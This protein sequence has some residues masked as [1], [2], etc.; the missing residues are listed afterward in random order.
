MTWYK[1]FI[2]LRLVDVAD[3][4]K[5]SVLIFEKECGELVGIKIQKE[6]AEVVE[7]K[8]IQECD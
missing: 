6:G 2:G 8:R 3:G 1:E 5:S 4:L 7:V